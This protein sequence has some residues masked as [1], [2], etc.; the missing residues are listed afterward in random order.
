[1]CVCACAACACACVCV[2][3]RVCKYVRPPG[4]RSM[5]NQ[6]VMASQHNTTQHV[7]MY[8][9]R[10]TRYIVHTSWHSQQRAYSYST[11]KEGAAS[12]GYIVHMYARTCVYT[13]LTKVQVLFCCEYYSFQASSLLPPSSVV[14]ASPA[15]TR[16]YIILSTRCKCAHICRE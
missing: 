8:L 1:M 12:R 13:L 2:C 5:A 11:R 16:T 6:L 3:V 7:H 9:V 15:L 10:G 4:Q 14:L